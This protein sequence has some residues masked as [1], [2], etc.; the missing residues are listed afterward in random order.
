MLNTYL[1]TSSELFS[2]FIILW[3][4]FITENASIQWAVGTVSL[5]KRIMFRLL[6]ECF[7]TKL[8]LRGYYRWVEDQIWKRWDGKL[9]SY[10]IMQSTGL[11]KV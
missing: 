7:W 9:I 2:P 10:H 8:R 1:R 3:L 6:N 5:I 11:P 4:V